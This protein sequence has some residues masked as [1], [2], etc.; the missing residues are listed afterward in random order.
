MRKWMRIWLWI[1]VGVLLPALC[2]GVS[3][4]VF[5]EKPASDGY[6]AA[7]S[8]K[9]TSSV[10]VSQKRVGIFGTNSL[11]KHKRHSGG[12]VPKTRNRAISN[13]ANS[14]DHAVDRPS[15]N[16]TYPS[17]YDA[18]GGTGTPSTK[19]V[20]A[21]G[22][23]VRGNHTVTFKTQM[24]ASGIAGWA[25][26]LK[27]DSV[28]DGGYASPPTSPTPYNQGLQFMG[29]GVSK[30]STDATGEGEMTSFD[31]TAPVT[32]DE[33]VWAL[34]G[35]EDASAG[36]RCVMGI[37]TVA[38]CFPDKN[39]A[40]QVIGEPQAPSGLKTSDVW[41]QRAALNFGSFN[42][43]TTPE[44]NRLQITELDGLQTL[45]GLGQLHISDKPGY[46][47]N[48]HSRDLH[49]LKYLSKLNN[50][51]ASYDG[52]SDL[53]NLSGFPDMV[54]LHLAGNDISDVSVLSGMS[55]LQILDLDNNS[56]SDVSS[57]DGLT[58]LTDLDLDHNRI[59]D[60]S[61]FSGLS[62]LVHLNLSDN[63]ISNVS[64]LSGLSNLQTLDLDYN[65]I[66]DVSV[67][68]ASPTVKLTN[69]T[70]LYLNHNAIVHVS[71]LAQLHALNTLQLKNNHIQSIS[72][73]TSLTKIYALYL[74][75]NEIRDISVINGAHFPWLGVLGLSNNHIG[76]V[77]SLGSVTTLTKLWLHYNN[78]S[79]VSSLAGLTHLN[80]L[81]LG[82]NH[83]SDISPLKTLTNLSSGGI[84]D[85]CDSGDSSF[86]ADK[87][88]VTLSDTLTADPGLS[89]P[90]AVSLKKSA[91]GSVTSV[92]VDPRS[93][94]PTLPV[95]SQFD[96]DR[97]Q[98]TWTGPMPFAP[99]DAPKQLNQSFNSYAQ[100]ANAYGIFSGTITG[101]YKVAQHTVTF[102]PSGGTL[103]SA[104]PS[105]VQVHSGYKIEAPTAAPTRAGYR[106]TGWYAQVNSSG[107][108]VGDTFDFANTT[109]TQ[110]VTLHAGWMRMADELPL[111]GASYREDLWLGGLAV[112]ALCMA[113]G[114]R[115]LRR[116]T[117]IQ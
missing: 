47:L 17:A 37:D 51:F 42:Y 13:G 29:W 14:S 94:S 77:S 65:S 19:A 101:Y 31:L 61:G 46:T 50:L 8:A 113:L 72:S 108:G 86:C 60:V 27:T 100:F 93:Y 81:F 43:N 104:Q 114:S 112:L 5:R 56:I 99:E 95:G 33:T 117:T 57:I 45:T 16:T 80:T 97:Q 70:E 12:L 106:F 68:I 32:G 92:G 59:S 89:V 49:Q 78:I 55:K 35:Y 98:L 3:V 44:D 25:I 41:T 87:Q 36:H 75:N 38:T 40:Q 11:T 73:L 6:A 52:I 7:E 24:D 67:L 15:L 2:L 10:S 1:A 115:L 4:I 91:D 85:G 71:S 9:D 110:D 39:L 22:V 83:I 103:P 88:T 20:A 53:S 107:A 58:N 66:T 111:T 69:L 116:H 76:D 28:A 21:H 26:T 48:E 79:D 102:D 30:N 96:A 84:V 54:N 105:T 90:T 34:W 63:S 74:D 23:S 62:K 18:N 64:S 82:S 109:V